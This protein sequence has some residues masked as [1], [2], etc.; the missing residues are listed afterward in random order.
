MLRES[1]HFHTAVV[2][3]GGAQKDGTV[4]HR[5]VRAVA[6]EINTSSRFP[7]WVSVIDSKL[8]VTQLISDKVLH[9]G[10]FGHTLMTAPLPVSLA[11]LSVCRPS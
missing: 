8:L 5:G 9:A 1:P 11:K 3:R 6:G 7:N 10:V 4:E 2:V